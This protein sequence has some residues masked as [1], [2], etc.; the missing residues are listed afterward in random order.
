[1]ASWLE[2]LGRSGAVG[3]VGGMV[4]AY[5]ENKAK[6]QNLYQEM[7]ARR[8]EQLRQA[9]KDE[10]DA[11]L[12]AI[13]LK[14]AEDKAKRESDDRESE[15]IFLE[16][17][18]LGM[19]VPAP[20]DAAPGTPSTY[21]PYTWEESSKRAIE[22]GA[23][24]PKVES[25]L[26][27]TEPSVMRP[28]RPNWD[29]AKET[30][31][32]TTFRTNPTV[33]RLEKIAAA[34]PAK[35]AGVKTQLNQLG[36]RLGLS[37][38]GF[39]ESYLDNIGGGSAQVAADLGGKKFDRAVVQSDYSMAQAYQKQFGEEQEVI[40]SLQDVDAALKTI[41]LKDGIWSDP[42]GANIP[43]YGVGAAPLRKYLQD[44]GAV[45]LRQSM[46]GLSIAYRKKYFGASLTNN[47]MEAYESFIG[48]GKVSNETAL[49]AALQK[50]AKRLYRTVRPV[51]TQGARQI[52]SDENIL[53][54]EDVPGAGSFLKEKKSSGQLIELSDE[55]FEKKY[56]PIK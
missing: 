16:D 41:G 15:R 51:V 49:M 19:E 31:F 27:M 8:A 30:E 24:T 6:E 52:L 37:G 7:V 45:E 29:P 17:H 56:G 36:S 33:A 11:K 38:Q 21:R 46:E 4:G 1:M 14:S 5:A 39:F 47:E 44:K 32:N 35:A 48:T 53:T 18:K 54:H 25:Y 55:E 50:I 23:F 13:N 10:M 22:Q 12:T 3:K 9:R 34:D 2:A 40:S 20:K 28:N 26:K 43:G 42:A